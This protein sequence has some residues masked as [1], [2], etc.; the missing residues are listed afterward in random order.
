M[1]NFGAYLEHRYEPPFEDWWV[2]R[3]IDHDMKQL[4]AELLSL[5]GELPPMV[6]RLSRVLDEAVIRRE[7]AWE[8]VP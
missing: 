2:I 5:P 7:S 1:A 3:G 8:S 6:A 4:S